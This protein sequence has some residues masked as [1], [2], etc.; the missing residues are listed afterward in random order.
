M[1]K[2]I[3][4]NLMVYY[5]DL[6]SVSTLHHLVE[7]MAEKEGVSKREMFERLGIS[8]GTLYQKNV[9]IETREKIIREAVQRL[10]EKAVEVLYESIKAVYVNFLIDLLSA[11]D[12]KEVKTIVNENLSLLTTVKDPERRKVVEQFLPR[13]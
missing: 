9:G 3:L 6:V 10:G 2:N 13:H 5:A 8:R 11:Y 7:L 12:G 1:D 4:S